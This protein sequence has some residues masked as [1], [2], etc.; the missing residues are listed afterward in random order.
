MLVFGLD[1]V[2]AT[3]PAFLQRCQWLPTLFMLTI[4]ILYGNGYFENKFLLLMI[5]ASW[6]WL[7]VY[8]LVIVVAVTSKSI[9]K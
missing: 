5:H 9:Q 1:Q 8:S 6:A 7:V 4:R 3:A 2:K